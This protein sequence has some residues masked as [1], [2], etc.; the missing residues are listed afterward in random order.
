MHK[1]KTQI[2]FI[3]GGMTFKNKKDYIHY[4]ETKAIHKQKTP[5]REGEYLTK[6][7]AN[8]C[9]I[10]RPRMPLEDNAKYNEWKIYFERYIPLLQDNCILIGRS[11]GGIFLAKYLSENKFPKRI[12]SVYL[13]CAPFDNTSPT[14]DLVWGFRLWSDLSLLERNC[15]NLSLLFSSDDE[16]VPVSHAEKYRKKLP[17][18]TITI[19]DDKNGHFMIEKFPE[20]IEMIKKDINLT[21]SKNTLKKVN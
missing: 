16:A 1:E 17:H 9:D 2:L 18:A 12:L 10:I 4:L 20:I 15:K 14:E 8:E 7:L 5:R 6:K 13:V 21:P 19:Y 3:H 11:L